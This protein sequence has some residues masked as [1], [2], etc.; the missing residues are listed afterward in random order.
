MW[1]VTWY[2]FCLDWFRGAVHVSFVVLEEAVESDPADRAD[3]FVE[4][5]V[6]GLIGC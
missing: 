5:P 1:G 4:T 3:W 6:R 2:F